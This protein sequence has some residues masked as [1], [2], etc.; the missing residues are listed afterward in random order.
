MT[1]TKAQRKKK[2]EANR[3]W[4]KLHGAEYYADYYARKGLKPKHRVK[5]RTK[6]K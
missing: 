2:S 1:L 3:K 4:Y 5:G 6:A